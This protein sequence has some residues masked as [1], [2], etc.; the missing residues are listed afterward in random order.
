[1]ILSRWCDDLRSHYSIWK[2][3]YVWVCVWFV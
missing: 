2:F 3:G 1:M